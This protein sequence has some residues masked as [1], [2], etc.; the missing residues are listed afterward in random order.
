MMVAELY[1]MEEDF[2]SSAKSRA[3]G[4]DIAFRIK[5]EV[6]IFQA[7]NQPPATFADNR[8]QQSR[9]FCI[10][11]KALTYFQPKYLSTFLL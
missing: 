4:L 7:S 5:L 1:E 2:A 9:Y 6:K 3:L 11:Y 8:R 10:E